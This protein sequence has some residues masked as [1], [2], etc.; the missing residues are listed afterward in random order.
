MASR[1]RK[2]DDSPSSSS[3]ASPQMTAHNLTATP[4]RPSNDDQLLVCKRLKEH[5]PSSS[6]DDDAIVSS[7]SSS[8]SS[9]SPPKA[10]EESKE[11]KEKRRNQ[12]QELMLWQA[13]LTQG[14]PI[15][16]LIDLELTATDDLSREKLK[17]TVLVLDAITNRCQVDVRKKK[18]G[19]TIQHK[20]WLNGQLNATTGRWMCIRMRRRL[21]KILCCYRVGYWSP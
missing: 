15:D 17:G 12:A 13:V 14:A 6:L 16:L 2:A 4:A 19:V 5:H 21:A 20:L 1:K 10:A 9:S 3:D 18:H 11:A 8:S 7:S